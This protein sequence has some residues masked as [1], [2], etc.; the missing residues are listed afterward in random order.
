M[1]A[2]RQ[3]LFKVFCDLQ[4][5]FLTRELIG[6]VPWCCVSHASLYSIVIN[7]GGRT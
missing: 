5:V 6:P 7:G 3:N 2:L 4:F 1:G